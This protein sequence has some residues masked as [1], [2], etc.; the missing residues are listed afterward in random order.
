MMNRALWAVG[1]AA[2]GFSVGVWSVI[3]VDTFTAGNLVCEVAR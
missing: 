1:F 3:A 2:I